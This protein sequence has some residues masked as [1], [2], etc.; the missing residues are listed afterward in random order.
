MSCLPCL[1]DQPAIGP[2]AGGCCYE[3]GD[4]VRAALGAAPL[5]APAPIDL[6]ALARERLR[7]AGA[8]AVHD[9]GL[10]TM[11]TDRSLFFSHRRD[12]GVTGRQAGIIVRDGS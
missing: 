3:V 11:C 5:G 2:A 9:C 1:R 6:K 4:D 7:A 10:C 12:G 8:H